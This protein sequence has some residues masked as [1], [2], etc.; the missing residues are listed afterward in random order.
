M[1]TIEH[2]LSAGIGMI[3]LAVMVGVGIKLVMFLERN[4]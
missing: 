4:K 1:I 2:F 3:A